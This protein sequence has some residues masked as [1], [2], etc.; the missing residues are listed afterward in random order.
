MLCTALRKILRACIYFF[1]SKTIFIYDIC[2]VLGWQPAF[3]LQ[4]L[5]LIFNMP[6]AFELFFTSAQGALL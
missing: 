2:N 4:I 6:T 3:K 1:K 5:V